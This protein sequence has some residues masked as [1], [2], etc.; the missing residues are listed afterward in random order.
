MLGNRHSN[1]VGM[2]GELRVLSELLLRGFS[3]SK[4]LVDDGIDIILENG[5]T[6]QVKTSNTHNGNS[7]SYVIPL[8]SA[9]WIKGQKK[10]DIR[11]KAKY[12]IIWA[13]PDNDFYIIPS[14]SFKNKTCIYLNANKRNK[15]SKFRNKW[16]RL[17][18]RR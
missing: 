2:A 17:K 4:S 7:Q 11:I 12:F 16:E 15:Y 13:I 14:K 18:K 8:M 10:R 1:I 3:P 6:L 9:K 5:K